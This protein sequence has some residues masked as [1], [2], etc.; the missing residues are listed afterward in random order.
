MLVG[1]L[2]A[3]ALRQNYL[4][5]I[6][7][8]DA[9]NGPGADQAID[10]Q[11]EVALQDA[12]DRMGIQWRRWR[13]MTDPASGMTL[14]QDYDRAGRLLPFV[15]LSP[16]QHMYELTMEYKD[17]QG[18]TRVRLYEGLDTSPT[19]QPIYTTLPL[20]QVGFVRRTEH[21]LI[22]DTLVPNPAVG[23][24]WAVDYIFGV[25]QLPADVA[26][27]ISLSAAMTILGL[28][29]VGQDV[30]GGLEAQ[31]LTQDGVQESIRYAGSGQYGAYAPALAALQAQRDMID[32]SKLRMRYQGS[33]FP[34]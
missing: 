7:L 4:R 34:I 13:L 33:K 9:W 10:F 25:G 15:P 24:G 22:P 11:L 3:T 6:V 27:W 2:S 18:L 8:G 16:E 5:G 20:A 17:V 30:S 21:V 26:A 1:A 31:S 32:L 29:Q 23:Q 14:G 28:A 19:P 12:E